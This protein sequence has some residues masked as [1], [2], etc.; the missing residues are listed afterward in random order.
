MLNPPLSWSLAHRGPPESH[1]LNFCGEN[2]HLV[3]EGLRESSSSAFST[4]LLLLLLGLS[5]IAVRFTSHSIMQAGLLLSLSRQT[6]PSELGLIAAS[7]SR[8][9]LTKSPSPFLFYRAKQLF[10][11]PD[12]KNDACTLFLKKIQTVHKNIGKKNKKNYP[13]PFNKR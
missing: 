11:C 13:N 3:S 7:R 1:R 10:L 6:F 9:R 5:R 8:S 4:T 2:G 12:Y